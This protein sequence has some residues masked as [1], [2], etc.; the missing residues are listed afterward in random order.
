MDC[1]IAAVDSIVDIAIV[2]A[3]PAL[4]VVVVWEFLATPDKP[5]SRQGYTCPSDIAMDQSNVSRPVE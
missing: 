1:L 5:R 3:V 2:F 4:V